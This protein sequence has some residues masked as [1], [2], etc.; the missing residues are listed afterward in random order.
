MNTHGK[1]ETPSETSSLGEEA[2]D[3]TSPHAHLA[4]SDPVVMAPGEA[5][6]R[7]PEKLGHALANFTTIVRV[8]HIHI[9]TALE[10]YLAHAV[11]STGTIAAALLGVQNKIDGLSCLRDDAC[12]SG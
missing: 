12:S 6:L 8:R 10:S 3:S 9:K 5:W 4:I 1:V 2:T 7:P 11:R